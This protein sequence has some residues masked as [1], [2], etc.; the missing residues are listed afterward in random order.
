MKM[1]MKVR[2]K[3]EDEGEHEDETGVNCSTQYFRKLGEFPPVLGVDMPF[4]AR[5]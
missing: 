4:A 2:S 3:D 1:R 5:S